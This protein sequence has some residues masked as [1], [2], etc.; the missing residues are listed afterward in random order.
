M[1]YRLIF[2]KYWVLND[3][4][5]NLCKFKI[6]P[7]VMESH[8][9]KAL[10]CCTQKLSLQKAPHDFQHWEAYFS[11]YHK[12]PHT[13]ATELVSGNYL[14]PNSTIIFDFVPKFYLGFYVFL[15]SNKEKM[16]CSHN[17]SKN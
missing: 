12:Q 10:L 9:H 2:F 5:L 13:R 17:L 7:W 6:P 8:L 11:V 15:F 1:Y 4:S 16:K 3:Y 14:Y